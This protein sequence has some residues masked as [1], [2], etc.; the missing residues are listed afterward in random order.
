MGKYDTLRSN[1]LGLSLLFAHEDHRIHVM[2]DDA[3]HPIRRHLLP[4][5]RDELVQA[6]FGAGP[7]R[8]VK[9]KRSG[10]RQ[11]K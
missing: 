8:S 9:V 6:L 2:Q 3:P 4:A 11:A 7:A 5:R 1:G 10:R